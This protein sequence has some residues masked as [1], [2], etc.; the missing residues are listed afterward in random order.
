[1]FLFEWIAEVFNEL[2]RF[3]ADNFSSGGPAKR[4]ER[5]LRIMYGRGEIDQKT[6]FRLR[7]SLEKGYFIEG[8]LQ[9]AHHQGIV[10]LQ[11]EGRYIE[12]HFDPEIRRGL[13]QIYLKRAMLD[14]VR[15]EMNQALKA[16]GAQREWMTRQADAVRD[17]A[18]L[19]LPD[20]AA[21][22]AFLEIRQDLL[23]RL[24][25]LDRRALQVQ[26]D[27]RQID[28]LAAELG[29]YEAE[30]MLVDSQEHYASARLVE[31]PVLAQLQAHSRLYGAEID[32]LRV[33]Q[34]RLEQPRLDPS[35]KQQR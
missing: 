13:E 21:A 8:E 28:V 1:M 11:R 9:T 3:M 20:E 34:P 27:L 23:D 25:A 14:E 18:Q 29:M 32:Q 30:L 15:Y 17:E 7:A 22:R 24:N 2:Y 33:E 16:L 19:A 6:F 10:R 31:S 35:S 5:Q 26:Q 4:M 12:H